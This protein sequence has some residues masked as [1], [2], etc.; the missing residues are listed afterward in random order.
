MSKAPRIYDTLVIGAGLSGLSAAHQLS[1]AGK[2]VLVLEAKNRIEGHIDTRRVGGQTVELGLQS[3]LPTDQLA[4]RFIDRWGLETYQPMVKGKHLLVAGQRIYPMAGSGQALGNPVLLA[5]QRALKAV[6]RSVHR[7]RPAKLHPSRPGA[8]GDLK[9]FA[10]YLKDLVWFDHSRRILT[11]HFETVLGCDLDRLSWQEAQR[12]LVCQGPQRITNLMGCADQ[13]WIDGGAGQLVRRLTQEINVSPGRPV[14]RVEEHKRLFCVK[15]TGFRYYAAH[16]LLA[17]SANTARGIEW[18][19]TDTP[20]SLSR[21]RTFS[22]SYFKAV[23]VYD[24]P[25]WRSSH[26]SGHALLG[27]SYPF[28]RVQDGSGDGSR[29]VLIVEAFGSRADALARMQEDFRKDKIG[30]MLSKVF[31]AELRR[32]GD[33]EERFWPSG[34]RSGGFG[35]FYRPDHGQL[36]DLPANLSCVRPTGLLTFESTLAEGL[37]VA[38]EMLAQ[39]TPFYS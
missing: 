3:L 12:I 17:T 38:N 6:S 23:L 33:Y 19:L 15:G 18:D 24:R 37:R 34:D 4:H 22:S 14:T 21:P 9:T 5:V 10:D 39:S 2:D 13:R 29:G 25:H 28:Q 11:A 32:P 27:P 7:Q 16:L 35:T 30:R 36:E 31:G 20:S 8:V 26:R 1:I